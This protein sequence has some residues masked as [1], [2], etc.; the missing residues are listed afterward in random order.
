MLRREITI[1]FVLALPAAGFLIWVA[2][3]HDD[4]IEVVPAPPPQAASATPTAP[5]P[6]V[7]LE[8]GPSR[9]APA[10]PPF[11]P[12]G[13]D[14][15]VVAST[16]PRDAIH[17]VRGSVLDEQ[18]HPVA[19]AKVKLDAGDLR[20]T[21]RHLGDAITAPDGSFEV[22]LAPPVN[23]PCGLVL[24][25]EVEAPDLHARGKNAVPLNPWAKA[26]DSGSGVLEAGRVIVRAFRK[27]RVHVTGDTGTVE[28][29]G[30]NVQYHAWGSEAGTDNQ[31]K[32]TDAD[33]WAEASIDARRATVFVGKT[34]L[35]SCALEL[36]VEPDASEETLEVALATEATISGRIVAPEGK[37]LGGQPA[38]SVVDKTSRTGVAAKPPCKLDVT[39]SPSV[40][41]VKDG[42]FAVGGLALGH[43]YEL[44][45]ECP[46]FAA[47]TVEVSAPAEGVEIRF[48]AGGKLSVTIDH[49]P[50]E[51]ATARANAERPEV[52]L[53]RETGE[54]GWTKIEWH[55]KT[56][57]DHVEIQDLAPG[58]Y[59][60]VARVA[61]L[62]PG[63]SDPVR[64]E[65]GEGAAQVTVRVA[66]GRAVTVHV[67][68]PDGSPV[69]GA[70]LGYLWSG[71]EI[72]TAARSDEAGAC[73]LAGLPLDAVELRASS[74]GREGKAPVAAAD[75]DVTV[76]VEP[77]GR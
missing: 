30:V 67:V 21:Q 61:P 23:G 18:N 56:E 20:S 16:D 4:T 45:A 34:G 7:P 37:P 52:S 19:Q 31:V 15:R 33:G 66:P 5:R 55:G 32:L 69:A 10:A 27:I 24:S 8:P 74:E 2:T 25:A 70:L 46:G 53:L 59:R 6:G 13:P 39:I 63:L 71:V 75:T 57:T 35:E 68:G 22:A 9:P 44:K 50:L 49:P 3:R 11:A 77:K 36:E 76:R 17:S 47:A 14:P 65:A 26:H 60:A 12:R 40:R 72:A 64:V 62:A 43:S 1:A 54:G 28:G 41:V 29:A 73:S 42:R 48:G 58:S 38:L 51:D